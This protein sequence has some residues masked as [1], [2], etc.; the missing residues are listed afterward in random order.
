MIDTPKFLTCCVS[1][2][3]LEAELHQSCIDCFR[4]IIF[5]IG[6]FTRLMSCSSFKNF[7]FHCFQ[8]TRAFSLPWERLVCFVEFSMSVL[9]IF[10]LQLLDVLFA[11]CLQKVLAKNDAGDHFPLYAICLGFEL[12]TMIISEVTL[13][14]VTVFNSL[15]MLSVLLV[16]YFLFSN[17]RVALH[18]LFF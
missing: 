3:W 18:G 1:I 5:F 12:L 13:S 6:T 15:S 11:C 16:A 8:D 10:A 17:A 2:Y 9:Y 4:A 7:L 14:I